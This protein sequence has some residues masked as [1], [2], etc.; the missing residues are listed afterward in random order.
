M[1]YRN[2]TIREP[3]SPGRWVDWESCICGATYIEFRSYPSM[4]EASSI[5]RSASED[6][7]WRSR[8]V[9]LW[10]MHCM[11]MQEWYLEHEGCGGYGR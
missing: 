1:A 3:K 5:L 11:K 6:K 4:S 2:P 8:R 9:L 7:Q 10:I